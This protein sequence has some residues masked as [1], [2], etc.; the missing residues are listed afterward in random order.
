M[1]TP[2]GLPIKL[3]VWEGPSQ[4]AELEKDQIIKIEETEENFLQRFNGQ[5]GFGSTYTKGNQ[6]VQYNLSAG[7][8]YRTEQWSASA[9]YNSN[10]SASNHD[11]A[12]TR[13]EIQLSAQRSLPWNNSYYAGLADLLQSSQQGI[14][15]Q[16]T[17]GGG[18]GRYLK[19]TNR[20]SI[21]LTGGFGWQQINYQQQFLASATQYVTAGL[22]ASHLNLFYFDRTTLNVNAIL[23]PALSDPGRLHLNLNTSYYVKLW[24]NISWNISFYGNWDNRPPPGFSGSDYGANSGVSWSFGNR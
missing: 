21:S 5:V 11:L 23:L 22:I 1:T 6:S 10:L 7:I 18:I 9:S 14:T 17:L 2:N 20:A 16:T 3:E 13:N 12:S 8:N 4:R 24:K 19:N 15:L